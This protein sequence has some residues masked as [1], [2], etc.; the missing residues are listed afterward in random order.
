MLA[1]RKT[2]TMGIAY[3]HALWKRQCFNKVAYRK[4]KVSIH[5]CPNDH[6]LVGFCSDQHLMST[7]LWVRICIWVHMHIMTR[8]PPNPWTL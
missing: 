8:V 5:N 3:G 4:E 7:C 1:Y 2:A 6:V